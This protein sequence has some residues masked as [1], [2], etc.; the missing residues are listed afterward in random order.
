MGKIEA[1]QKGHERYL[2]EEVNRNISGLWSCVTTL[3][4]Q[5]IESS[6]IIKELE[7]GVDRLNND[8]DIYLPGPRAPTARFQE[9]PSYQRE[10]PL[11][12]SNRRNPPRAADRRNRRRETSL[13]ES[14]DS[15]TDSGE[16]DNNG[17]NNANRRHYDHPGAF[18]A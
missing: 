12:P 2:T 14:S 18:L 1:I 17:N 4:E 7:A 5:N 13:F 10:P 15:D 8:V 6:R 3:V 9:P 11:P 16:E